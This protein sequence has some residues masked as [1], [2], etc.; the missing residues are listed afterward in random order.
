M[1]PKT[2]LSIL[3]RHR[4]AFEAYRKEH[5]DLTLN[6][7]YANAVDFYLQFGSDAGLR[8]MLKG[9][10][11]LLARLDTVSAYLV[12]LPS[13]IDHARL[14]AH[15]T[16]L[17]RAMTTTIQNSAQDICMTVAQTLETAHQTRWRLRVGIASLGAFVGP[18]RSMP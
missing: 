13:L 14:E 9:Q 17:A 7:F 8:P 11:E 2:T 15:S 12:K 16:T 18:V 5:P 6:Q 4:A 3:P 1:S 10:H